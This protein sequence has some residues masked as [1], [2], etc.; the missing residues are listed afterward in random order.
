M[1]EKKEKS[2][3]IFGKEVIGT[4]EIREFGNENI[5]PNRVVRKIGVHKAPT[6]LPEFEEAFSSV[7][8]AITVRLQ[9][10]GVAADFPHRYGD[11]GSSDVPL[12]E[13]NKLL[14]KYTEADIAHLYIKRSGTVETKNDPDYENMVIMAIGSIKGST[15]LR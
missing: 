14:G 1:K 8:A 11:M 2:I 4:T 6:L 9:I 7:Q 5:V 10:E 13:L 15:P 12:N 3:K